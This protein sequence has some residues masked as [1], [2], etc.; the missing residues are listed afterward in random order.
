MARLVAVAVG[1]AKA[2]A[3]DD[4]TRVRDASA[5]EEEDVRRLKTEVTRLRVEQ[6]SLLLEL[7]ASRDEVSA[8]IPK[9]ARTRKPW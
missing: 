1:K 6:T 5:A 2:M 9:R 8:L 3:K 7:K 4:L